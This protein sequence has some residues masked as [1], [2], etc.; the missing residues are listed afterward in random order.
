M[1]SGYYIPLRDYDKSQNCHKDAGKNPIKLNSKVSLCLIL[2]EK[3]YVQINGGWGW[4][5]TAKNS[6]TAG[7]TTP[8]RVR[9]KIAF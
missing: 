3:S 8:V 5:H 9:I 4:R 6:R 7:L 2:I 1:G